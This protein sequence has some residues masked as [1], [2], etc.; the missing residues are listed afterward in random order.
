MKVKAK[1]PQLKLKAKTGLKDI[2]QANDIILNGECELK[3]E[4]QYLQLS[5]NTSSSIDRQ[6]SNFN[7]LL[8]IGNIGAPQVD[9]FVYSSFDTRPINGRDINYRTSVAFASQTANANFTVPQGYVFVLRKI[10]GFVTSFPTGGVVFDSITAN[11]MIDGSIDPYNAGLTL[12]APQETGTYAVNRY[13]VKPYEFYSVIDENSVVTYHMDCVTNFNGRTIVIYFFGNL[14]QKTGV[15][16]N[17]EIGFDTRPYTNFKPLD[18]KT[19]YK[20]PKRT[21]K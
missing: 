10:T 14:L 13:D 4:E 15:P 16:A 2:K 20:Q 19:I 5:A 11:L 7:Q 6:R 8:T 12:I 21:K 1:R 3:Q 18:K 17:F 9:R